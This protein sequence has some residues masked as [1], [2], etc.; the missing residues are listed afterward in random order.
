VVLHGR[1][2]TGDAPAIIAV[3][4]VEEAIARLRAIG[5]PMFMEVPCMTKRI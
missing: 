2:R 5:A 3:G 4:K 1:A